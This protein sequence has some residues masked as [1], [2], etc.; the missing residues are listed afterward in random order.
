MPQECSNILAM[1]MPASDTTVLTILR[2]HLYAECQLERLIHLYLPRGD[3]IIKGARVT[4]YQKLM[5]VSSFDI[6][7]DRLIQCLKGLNRVRNECAHNSEK[8]LSVVDVETIGCALGTRFVQ[9]RRES[10]GSVVVFLNL[11]LAFLFGCLAGGIEALEENKLGKRGGKT[12]KVP[13]AAPGK[14]PAPRK[15]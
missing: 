7:G 12:G 14:N 10:K 6:L 9:Y 8:K 3:R 11:V 4:Y 15:R 5:I 1:R 13:G 2:G